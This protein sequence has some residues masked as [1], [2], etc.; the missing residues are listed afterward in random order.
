MTK[1]SDMNGRS[2]E[3]IT[4][5]NL[6]SEIKS[7]SLPCTITER[8][9]ESHLKDCESFN[10]LSQ[11]SDAK[12]K[13]LYNDY[14]KHSHLIIDWV[15]KQFNLYDSTSIL[16]DKLPDK[17]GEFGDI[18]DIRIIKNKNCIINLSLK[19]NSDSIKHSRIT[20]LPT[21]VGF[22]KDSNEFSSYSNQLNSIWNEIKNEVATY[23]SSSSI[24]IS[25]FNQLDNIRKN[26]KEDSIL[27]PFYNLI[28]SFFSDY[29]TSSDQCNML[30]RYLVGIYD[31]YKIIN[32]PKCFDIFSFINISSP[33]NVS[34]ARTSNDYLLLSFNNGWDLSIRLHNGDNKL[35]PSLKCDVKIYNSPNIEKTV[36]KK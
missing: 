12:S 34:F 8:A 25:K 3:A 10:L 20:Q 27:N 31:F 35:S 29:C 23:N 24:K 16:I 9:Y 32:R 28:E 1:K 7:H 2:F 17:A 4:F 21:W 19:N 6:A 13:K 5:Y 33:T 30:F 15:F 11:E 36:L 26:Y 22:A 14:I 18:T